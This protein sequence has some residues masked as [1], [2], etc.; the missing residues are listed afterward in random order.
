MK[1]N[2]GGPEKA[3][4]EDVTTETDGSRQIDTLELP[5][6]DYLF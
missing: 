2:Y 5:F 4:E 6:K 1:W 3:Y